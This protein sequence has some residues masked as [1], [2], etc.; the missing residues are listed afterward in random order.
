MTN[1]W[2]PVEKDQSNGEAGATDGATITLNGVT[3]AKGLGAHAGSDVRYALN[4][5]CSDVD[6][7]RRDRRRGRQP[8]GAPCS[9]SGPT[10]SRNTTAG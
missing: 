4:G 10:A 6:G 7:G 9:R 1:G 3:Y 2:G 5:A 8:G